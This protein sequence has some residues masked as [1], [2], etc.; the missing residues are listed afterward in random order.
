MKI[1]EACAILG[2]TTWGDLGLKA[3]DVRG[4][5]TQAVHK[6]GHDQNVDVLK[7]ARDLLLTDIRGRED[8]CLKCNGSGWVGKIGARIRCSH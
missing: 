4:A 1:T 6:L 8:L 5:Y 3:E 2:L 7:A